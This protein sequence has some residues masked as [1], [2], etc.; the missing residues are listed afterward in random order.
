M[1]VNTNMLILYPNDGP[2]RGMLTRSLTSVFRF[3]WAHTQTPPH[4]SALRE[5][6]HVVGLCAVAGG[7]ERSWLWS[8]YAGHLL[9]SLP[10][11]ACWIERDKASEA[12]EMVKPYDD[13]GLTPV[14]R[15]VRA[16]VRIHTP[17]ALTTL[18]DDKMKNQ[19]YWVL[20]GSEQ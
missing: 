5:P 16:W 14:T 17:D 3:P 12:L 1:P 19:P 11:P 10:L 9:F 20:M 7:E 8:G 18:H 4:S 2:S 6:S 13:R 15:W